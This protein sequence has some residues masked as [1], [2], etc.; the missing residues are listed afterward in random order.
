MSSVLI[1]H[2]HESTRDTLRDILANHYTVIT[3]S[4]AGQ[5]LAAFEQKAPLA[6]AFLE[7]VRDPQTG[8]LISLVLEKQKRTVVVAVTSA[9]N[10]I[11]GVQAVHSGA[12]GYILSPP[13]KEEILAI[14]RKADTPR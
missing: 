13:R 10:E 4:D 6:L 11:C 9:E 7:A 14:A 5:C 8:D 12:E 2:T 1:F 3:V